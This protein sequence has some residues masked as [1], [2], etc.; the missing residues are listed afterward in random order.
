LTTTPSGD[1]TLSGVTGSATVSDSA[2]ITVTGTATPI[3]PTGSV[4]FYL[5]GPSA[6]QI[7]T[8]DATGSLKN[9]VNLN[10]A[11]QNGN[12]F[13]VGSGD[14]TVNA[15]GY[16]CWFATWPGDSNYVPTPPATDFH[17]GS[18][19]ECFKITQPTSVSTTLHETNSGGT[20][21][22]PANNGTTIVI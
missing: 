3:A 20:D 10:T 8:C 19:T 12:V 18:A 17:D 4:K 22:N 16:Y 15:S 11:T 1:G 14:Q 7:S 6:T 21:V 13:T 9:T 2:A 5:C